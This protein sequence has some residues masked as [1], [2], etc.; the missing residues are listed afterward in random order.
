MNIQAIIFDFDGVLVRSVE[1]KHQAFYQ[2]MLDYGEDFAQDVYNYHLTDNRNR[3]D[4][5]EYAAKK[6]DE[7]DEFKQRK[8]QD[9]KN[10]VLDKIKRADDIPGAELFI[11]ADTELY[12]F[13]LSGSPHVELREIVRGRNW[14]YSFS[15]VLGT[16]I[17]KSH[18]VSDILTQYGLDPHQIIFIG[19]ML[20]DCRV[21]MEHGLHF[22]GRTDSGL[23]YDSKQ[24]HPAITN[25]KKTFHEDLIRL[26]GNESS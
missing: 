26:I 19:D 11:K 20:S 1:L 5:V 13:V 24:Y 9:Y 16:P 12:Q 4:V 10:L 23:F 2:F 18:H 6:L 25:F 3:F 14:A 15:E 8:L 17:N 21:A 22:I 7:G